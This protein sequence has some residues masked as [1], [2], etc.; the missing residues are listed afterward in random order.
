MVISTQKTA[1]IAGKYKTPYRIGTYSRHGLRGRSGSAAAATFRPPPV[2]NQPTIGQNKSIA[3]TP[4]TMCITHLPFTA[5]YSI[6]CNKLEG[7]RP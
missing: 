3:I 5:D 4:T 7:G 6:I 1:K 2:R